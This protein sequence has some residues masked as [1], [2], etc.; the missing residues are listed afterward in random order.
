M[1]KLKVGKKFGKI[2]KYGYIG[3]LFVIK[4]GKKIFVIG[5][6]YYLNLLIFIIYFFLYFFINYYIF[7]VNYSAFNVSNFVLLIALIWS[8]VMLTISDPGINK[9]KNNL[10]KCSCDKCYINKKKNFIHCSFCDVCI[11][12][13]DH[14]C[15]FIGKCIGHRNYDIFVWFIIFMLLYI[16]SLFASVLSTLIRF[17]HIN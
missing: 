15:D 2:F 17:Y 4:Y 12:N 5:M 1:D 10:V 6:N 11:R 9:S 16:L 8:H 14:H 7:S 3:N 13:L